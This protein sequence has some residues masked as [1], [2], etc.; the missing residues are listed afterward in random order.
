[1]RW[2]KSVAQS[3]TAL[4]SSASKLFFTS[5]TGNYLAEG[6]IDDLCS[7]ESHVIAENSDL[8]LGDFKNVSDGIPI[9]KPETISFEYP[10]S[11]SEYDSIKLNPYGFFNVSCGIDGV[12]IKCFIKQIDYKPSEGQAAFTLIKAWQ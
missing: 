8:S 5:G 12:P 7:L 11:I 3:Y 1:M 9:Y 2:F 6:K 10:L 4:A